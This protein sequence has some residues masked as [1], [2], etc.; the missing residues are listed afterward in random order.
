LRLLLAAM[1][2]LAAVVVAAPPAAACHPYFVN[3]LAYGDNGIYFWIDWG[4]PH[5]LPML[6][7]QPY[8]EGDGDLPTLCI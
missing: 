3:D 6:C 7:L 8:H 4:C 1:L 2:V 5:F